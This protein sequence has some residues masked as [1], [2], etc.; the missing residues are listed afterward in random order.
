MSITL[1]VDRSGGIPGFDAELAGDCA[2]MH[3]PTVRE[4]ISD[5]RAGNDPCR[6]LIADDE[7]V[8]R[9]DGTVSVTFTVDPRDMETVE[10]IRRELKRAGEQAS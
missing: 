10:G 2:F 4:W 5:W 8:N 3:D 9:L 6:V 7:W 1:A